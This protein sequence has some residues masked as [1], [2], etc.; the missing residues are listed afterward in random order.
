M[1]KIKV[2]IN[3]IK[4]SALDFSN[5]LTLGHACD[6]PDERISS[7]T[8]HM[9]KDSNQFISEDER[10]AIDL[11]EQLSREKGLHYEIIDL[12]KAGP[13]A[14]LMF[15]IKKWKVPVISI[16]NETIMGLP[17]KETLESALQRHQT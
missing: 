8:R 13:L 17:T 15:I 3:T 1:G 16:E 10:K 9:P 14:R 12:A 2:Y 11:V 5:V 7:G 6:S 4:L